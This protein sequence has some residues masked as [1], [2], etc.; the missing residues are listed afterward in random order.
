MKIKS[1]IALSLIA[2]CPALQSQNLIQ[3]ND[4]GIQNPVVPTSP[5]TYRIYP[6]SPERSDAFVKADQVRRVGVACDVEIQYRK[7][8]P[9]KKSDRTFDCFINQG[10]YSLIWKN[11]IFYLS[12]CLPVTRKT[13][14]SVT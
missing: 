9:A 1:C 11:I 2:L 12:K 14:F 3:N 5:S 8:T 10:F 13:Q 6:V 7:S 4:F